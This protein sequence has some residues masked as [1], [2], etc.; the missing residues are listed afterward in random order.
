MKQPI[1]NTAATL[2]FMTANGPLQHCQICKVP[3]RDGERFMSLVGILPEDANLPNLAHLSCLK[4][5]LSGM[6]KGVTNVLTMAPVFSEEAGP[7]VE[8]CAADI[9]FQVSA[10]QGFIYG[11]NIIMLSISA[12]IDGWA[13]V[14][15]ESLDYG[16]RECAA[17]VQELRKARSR[18]TI[19][20]KILRSVPDIAFYLH[21]QALLALTEYFKEKGANEEEV[22]D[23]IESYN[24]YFEIGGVNNLQ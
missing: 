23:I 21:T 8:I 19:E 1:K 16:K 22:R 13:Y 12:H 2:H 3:V 20:S 18:Q 15:A 5:V 10:D 6:R 14:L 11:L 4:D 17:F 24:S 9:Q 7:L